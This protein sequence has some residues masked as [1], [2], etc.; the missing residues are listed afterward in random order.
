MIARA[1]VGGGQASRAGKPP[2]AIG[3]HRSGVT[4]IRHLPCAVIARRYS[5]QSEC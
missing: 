4:R 2:V 1:G 3:D 5:S